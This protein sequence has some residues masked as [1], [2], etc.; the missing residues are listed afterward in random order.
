MANSF[1][2]Y[3][4]WVQK[5]T[6][7]GKEMWELLVGRKSRCAAQVY[8]NACWHTFDHNGVGGENWK[9]YTIEQTKVQAAASAISQGFI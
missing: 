7:E 9:E 8:Y 1:K 2:P 4:R 5:T 6:Q 3:Y